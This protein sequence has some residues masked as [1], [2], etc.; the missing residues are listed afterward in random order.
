MKQTFLER[1]PIADDEAVDTLANL[2]RT[3]VQ[4]KTGYADDFTLSRTLQGYLRSVTL[5]DDASLD[6]TSFYNAMIK[7]NCGENK[8]AI[9]GLFHRYDRTASGKILIKDFTDSLFGLKPLANSVPE[10]REILKSIRQQLISRG[11]LAFRYLVK[12]LKVAERAQGALDVL[13]LRQ[14]FRTHGVTLPDG[15]FAKVFQY[16]DKDKNTRVSATELVVGLRPQNSEPRLALIRLTYLRLER[17]AEGNI[18]FSDLCNMYQP[19]KHPLVL[20][21]QK[22]ADAAF[23]E[24]KAS[25]PHGANDNITERDFLDYYEDLSVLIENDNYFELLVRSSWRIKESGSNAGKSN[26]EVLVTHLDGT[27][28]IESLDADLGVD[29]N[30]L[31]ATLRKQGITDVLKADTQFFK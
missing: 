29:T 6:A 1:L 25:W 10:V 7:L 3:K 23:K 8:F 27:H 22:T 4:L 17:N 24:F 12:D 19:E 14:L 30:A 2:L 15:D 11:D 31:I 20:K 13:Q 5:S 21:G 9:S 26:I 16:F 28:T 18:T